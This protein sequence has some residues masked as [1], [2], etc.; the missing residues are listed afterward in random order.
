MVVARNLGRCRI[1]GNA[2]TFPGGMAALAEDGLGVTLYKSDIVE[3]SADVW[4]WIDG[5]LAGSEP[6]LAQFL[7]LDAS[8]TADIPDE[9]ERV[10]RW[11]RASDIFRK[12]GALS[13]PLNAH[14]I[15]PPPPEVDPEKVWALAGGEVLK[16]RGAAWVPADPQPSIQFALM[17][18]TICAERQHCDLQAAGERHLVCVDC[19]A[20]EFTS[21]A[22]P[23]PG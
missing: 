11:L 6:T 22:E 10:S 8:E 5:F 23:R 1:L 21:S 17:A 2:H 3:A 13:Y 7:G 20:L 18:G 16:W 15:E 4:A 19:G 14:P 9:D 12:T